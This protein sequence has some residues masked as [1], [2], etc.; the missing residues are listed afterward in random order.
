MSPTEIARRS[1]YSWNKIRDDS[2]VI[3]NLRLKIQPQYYRWFSKLMGS[4]LRRRS[5]LETKMPKR[6]TNEK[7]QEMALFW[8]QTCKNACM[9]GLFSNHN[10]TWFIPSFY[11]C[12]FREYKMLH[13]VS[14]NAWISLTSCQQI[15]SQVCI[16]FW[17]GCWDVKKTKISTS[18]THFTVFSIWSQ[19]QNCC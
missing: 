17:P 12:K 15:C 6:N 5:Q 14:K 10:I 2:E 16:T 13:L 4:I 1:R 11:S 9:L 8:C 18:E 7:F 19:L 3:E